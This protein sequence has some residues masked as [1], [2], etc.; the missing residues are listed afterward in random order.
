MLYY[1]AENGA[2]KPLGDPVE[3]SETSAQDEA[4]KIFLTDND[5]LSVVLSLSRKD[6]KIWGKVFQMPQYKITEWMFPGKKKRGTKR[7][8]RKEGGK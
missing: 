8:S 7:R 4:P 1:C 3:I 2:F 5:E 6:K